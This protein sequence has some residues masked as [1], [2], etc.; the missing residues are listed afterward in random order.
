MA[1]GVV[2]GSSGT[3]QAKLLD[4]GQPFTLPEGSSWSWSTS[5]SN[6]TITPDPSD[7]TGATVIVAVPASETA[8]QIDVTASTV[9]PKG[10]TQKFTLTV[11]IMPPPQIFTVSVDQIA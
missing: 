10:E 3:F 2:A 6:A 1:N 9:D 5:N 8:T 7:P 11:P 4:N